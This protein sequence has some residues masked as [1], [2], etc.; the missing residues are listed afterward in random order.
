MTSNCPHVGFKSGEVF[1]KAR[2]IVAAGEKTQY[3]SAAYSRGHLHQLV[4]ISA[5][6]GDE[7]ITSASARHQAR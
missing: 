2:A 5:A 1:P 7:D 3:E 6:T 4:A